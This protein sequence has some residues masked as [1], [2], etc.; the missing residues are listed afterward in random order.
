[1]AKQ[2]Q[3]TQECSP[4]LEIFCKGPPNSSSLAQIIGITKKKSTY[5]SLKFICSSYFICCWKGF[6]RSEQRRQ[7]SIGQDRWQ[8]GIYQEHKALQQHH[9]YFFSHHPKPLNCAFF[10]FWD[11]QTHGTNCCRF[12]SLVGAHGCKAVARHTEL[13]LSLPLSLLCFVSVRR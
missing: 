6:S 8:W 12:Q 4:T 13:P 11:T 9:W 7:L 5:S 2:E 1:M 3:I 10:F